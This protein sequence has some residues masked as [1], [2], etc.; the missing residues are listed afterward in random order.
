MGQSRRDFRL[1]NQ[2]VDQ[3][4]Y[5]GVSIGRNLSNDVPICDFVEDE[6]TRRIVRPGKMT[7][8]LPAPA[9]RG[10]YTF[11]SERPRQLNATAA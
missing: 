9:E 10:A 4:S 7:L 6:D 1:T 3:L 11:A 2:A 5:R 8:L